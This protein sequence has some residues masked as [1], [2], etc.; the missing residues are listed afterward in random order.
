MVLNAPLGRSG[1]ILEFLSVSMMQNPTGNFTNDSFPHICFLNIVYKVQN[2]CTQKLCHYWKTFHLLTSWVTF[3]I[4]MLAKSIHFYLVPI[5]PLA[6]KESTFWIENFRVSHL[7]K[8]VVTRGQC[9]FPSSHLSQG[10]RGV[11]NWEFLV[12]CPV[13]MI[14]TL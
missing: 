7:R 12:C 8:P 14:D 3:Y 4:R 11:I 9:S 6:P 5:L 10:P 2:S 1:F 13:K